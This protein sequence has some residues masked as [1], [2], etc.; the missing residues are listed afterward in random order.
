MNGRTIEYV[1]K[2]NISERIFQMKEAQLIQDML[3]SVMVKV[4]CL[5]QKFR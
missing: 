4:N 1:P 2:L 3:P 5:S